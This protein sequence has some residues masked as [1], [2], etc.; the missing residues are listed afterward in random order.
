MRHNNQQRKQRMLS[1]Y[2]PALPPEFQ[3]GNEIPVGRATISRER[4]AEILAE[5]IEAYQ[6]QQATPEGWKPMPHFATT[7]MAL[8]GIE[9]TPNQRTLTP[10][11]WEEYELMSPLQQSLFRACKLWNTMFNAAPPPPGSKG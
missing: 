2:T 3:S 8:R 9:A 11:E 4:M 7:E 1:T 6:R 5:A 10:N